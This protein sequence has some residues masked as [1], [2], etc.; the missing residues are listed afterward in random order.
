MLE[1]VVPGDS[2]EEWDEKKEEFVYTPVSE[3]KTLQ[4]E[5][6]LLSLSKWE[7]L[8]GIRY[9]P[10]ENRTLDEIILYIQC[11]TITKNVKP[12]VYERLFKHKDLID[13]ISAYINAPMTATTFNGGS[14]A[15]NSRTENISSELIYYWMIINSIPVEFE[16]WHLNRLLTL[17]RLCNTKNGGGKKM[18]QAEVMRQYKSINDANRAKFGIKG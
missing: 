15:N 8:T 18:S 9:F 4:L 10:V 11:M 3:P 16:R 1:I 7:S 6:S 17:I 13:K 5:H 2:K 12:E 14:P